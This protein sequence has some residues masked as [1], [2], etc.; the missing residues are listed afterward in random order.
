MCLSSV[1]VCVCVCKCV[2]PYVLS[3]DKPRHVLLTS[4][5]SVY[6]KNKTKQNKTQAAL[7]DTVFHLRVHTFLS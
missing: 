7:D 2:C 3:F 6:T 1:C 5:H 4:G